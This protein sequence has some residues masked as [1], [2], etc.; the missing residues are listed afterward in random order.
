MS[1]S[2]LLDL[3]TLVKV[4]KAAPQVTVVPF[5]LA[6][7][8]VRGMA[9]FSNENK[10]NVDPQGQIYWT[11]T[12]KSLHTYCQFEFEVALG[13]V[14]RALKAMGLESWRKMDGFHIAWSQA[15]LEILQGHFK[16]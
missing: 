2:D 13:T 14:G 16:V 1:V 7:W 6:C 10:A 3:E 8:V 11:T 12:V 4:R 9:R 5:D 15:Q